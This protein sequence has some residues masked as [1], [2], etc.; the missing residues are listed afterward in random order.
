MIFVVEVPHT[1][2]PHAWFAYDGEDLLAK[3]AASDELQPWEIHDVATPRELLDVLD[4]DPADP[5]VPTRLPGIWALATEHGLDTPLYR[6]DHL[7]GRGQY[8]PEVVTVEQ[9]CEAALAA[10]MGPSEELTPLCDLRLWWTEESAVLSSE[11]PVEPLFTAPGGWRALHAL[12][13]QLLALDV[14]AEN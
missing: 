3:V 6:A 10:R 4:A 9:A 11:D 12:R 8:Q 7:L 1:G 13:E 5:T 14:V 2:E